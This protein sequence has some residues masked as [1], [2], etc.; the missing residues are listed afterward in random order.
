MLCNCSG[1]VNSSV[2][3]VVVEF[4]CGKCSVTICICK[5]FLNVLY[6]GLFDVLLRPVGFSFHPITS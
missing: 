2:I 6:L 5:C 3:M 4:V 1:I